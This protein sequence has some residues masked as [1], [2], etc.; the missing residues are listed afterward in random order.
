MK[1]VRSKLILIIL[2]I[3]SITL[4][5]SFAVLLVRQEM[6]RRRSGI[7]FQVYQ[8]MTGLVDVYNSGGAIDPSFWPELTGFGM[9][10]LNGISVYRYGSAPEILTN[11]D[12]ISVRGSSV[13]SGSSM[14][15]IRRSG[16]LPSM[17]G[18]NSEFSN[19][20]TN[21]PRYRQGNRPD[22]RMEQMMNPL[23]NPMMGPPRS[24]RFV[25]IE[26]NV[27][28]LLKE[29]QVVYFAVIALLSV[30]MAIVSLVILYSRK[31]AVYRDREQKT[32]HLVQLGEAARTLAHEIKNPLGVIRVQC[33]TLKR[34]VPEERQKNIDIIEEETERLVQMTN[35]VR[36]F[37]H[38]SEG[39]PQMCDVSFF[40][41]QCRARY[42]EQLHVCSWSGSSLFITIDQNRMMQV[43]D[44]LIANAIEAGG[45]EKPELSISL[46]R[47]Q[48]S[49]IVA[50]R[51]VGVSLE[52]KARLFELFFTTKARGSGIGLALAR[53]FIEQA[54]G[55]LRFEER[56]LGG[57][58]FVATLPCVK[59]GD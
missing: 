52:N 44:N 11:Q 26:I 1:P 39:N 46:R 53:R 20:D 51:G 33:A 13:L 12:A 43:L 10:T 34:T 35:R 31:I 4:S 17:H 54:G 7:E 23:M 29:G 47:N 21:S 48:V 56:S 9:Y 22:S 49:F 58:L 41:E 59:K 18:G 6:Q 24:N 28:T 32:A 25:F 42:S 5:V 55:S 8:I 3:L 45:T 14:T 50:D 16:P 40:L 15:I 57:S 30:F 36:D 38:N 37:L 19:R 27:E 2:I